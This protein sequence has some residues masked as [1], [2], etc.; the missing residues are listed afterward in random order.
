[1]T[2]TSDVVFLAYGGFEGRKVV[3]NAHD[4]KNYRIKLA[5]NENVRVSRD[6]WVNVHVKVRWCSLVTDLLIERGAV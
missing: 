1:M 3:M 6:K 4:S 5:H 2:V